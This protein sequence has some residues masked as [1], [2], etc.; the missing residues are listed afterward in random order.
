MCPEIYSN[1]KAPEE[2]GAF[3]ANGKLFLSSGYVGRL[4][5]LWTLDHIERHT[6]AISQGFK[7]VARNRGKMHENIVAILLLKKTKPLAVVKPFYRAFYHVLSF[8]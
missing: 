5:A 4:Q 6:I 7:A 1:K 8:S 2:S 3:C